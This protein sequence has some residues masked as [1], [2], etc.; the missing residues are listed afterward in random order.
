MQID[1]IKPTVKAPGTKRWNLKSDE[2]LSSFA[3][4]F[5]LRRCTQGRISFCECATGTGAGCMR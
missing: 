5:N 2:V 3:F 4:K 1:P